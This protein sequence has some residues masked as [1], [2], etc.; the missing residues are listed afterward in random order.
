MAVSC[1]GFTVPAAAWAEGSDLLEEPELLSIEKENAGDYLTDDND[2]RNEF[3]SID[4]LNAP[5]PTFAEVTFLKVEEPRILKDKIDNILTGITVLIAPEYDHYGYEIRRYMAEILDADVFLSSER[6]REQIQNMKA[7]G[8]ILN[9]W[10]EKYKKDIEGIE[11]DMAEHGA[12]SGER[13]VYT[14]NKGLADAFFMNARAWVERNSRYLEFLYSVGPEN[15]ELR[16]IK[17]I[18]FNN[19]EHYA[20]FQT[21]YKNRQ[22]AHLR[23]VEYEAFKMMVF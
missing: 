17:G 2:N 8:I 1:L 22:Q 15:Y 5:K 4:R 9:Y 20:P 3:I 7:A 6:M 18:R 13:G 14:Y 21:L 19:Y 10:H 12:T 16:P 11:A 23:I